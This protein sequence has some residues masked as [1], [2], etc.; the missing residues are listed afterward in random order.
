MSQAEDVKQLLAYVQMFYISRW[1]PG[2]STA[3]IL[4]K[5]LSSELGKT[6]LVVNIKRDADTLRDQFFFFV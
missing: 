5:K 6:K 4:H 2:H 3:R 1:R